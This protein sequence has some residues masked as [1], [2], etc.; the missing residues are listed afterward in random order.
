[1]ESSEFS[2]MSAPSSIRPF[3]DEQVAVEISRSKRIL[4]VHG[5]AQD[6]KNPNS[7]KQQWQNSLTEELSDSGFKL[8][9]DIEFDFPYY[10][11]LLAEFAEEIEPKSTFDAQ[12]R[13][14]GSANKEFLRFKAEMVESI[15]MAAGITHAQIK[16]VHGGN[17]GVRAGQNGEWVEST[18]KAL[19]KYS[20]S[21]TETAL[22]LFLR[23]VF[24]Y[25]RYPRVKKA[26]NKAVAEKLTEKK[27]V[28]IGHSLGSL[29][30]FNVLR[31]TTETLDISLFMTIGC[32]MGIR[33]ISDRLKPL[34]RPKC[35]NSWV[36]AYD[37][38]DVFAPYPLND[39]NF[40]VK[41]E[42][43]NFNGVKN[44]TDN[45]HGVEGYLSNPV[46]AQSVL[47]AVK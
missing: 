44:P 6:G 4:L 20:P 37:K 29:V 23:D 12:A 38:Q 31:Q 9:T 11:D 13:C 36:N 7:L 41:P 1:M 35:I 39:A 24:L 34:I 33:Y 10:G 32:P 40:K 2:D 28:V 22:E 3:I 8:P 5:I 43:I 27:T 46:V 45:H 30:S 16:N 19:D 18:I 42:I 21:F 26:I 14:T 15:R 47:H 17:T 25:T